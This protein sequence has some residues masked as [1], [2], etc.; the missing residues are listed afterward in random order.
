LVLMGS[1]FGTKMPS[2][3]HPPHHGRACAYTQKD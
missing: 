3:G 2:G 1:N